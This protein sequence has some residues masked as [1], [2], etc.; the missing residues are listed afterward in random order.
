MFKIIKSELSK[1]F[2][3]K[4][5]YICSAIIFLLPILDYA[6]IKMLLTQELAEQA[7]VSNLTTQSFILREFNAQFAAGGTVFIIITILI[8][9]LITSD[10]NNGTM[11]YSL[12]AVGRG[13]LIVGKIITVFTIELL[14][15]SSILISSILIGILGY[16]WDP[17]GLNIIQ[18]ITVYLLGWLSICSFSMLLMF[19]S[20]K[21]N[22]LIG[23][24]GLSLG[25][26][27]TLS[28]L[29]FV[30]PEKLKFLSLLESFVIFSSYNFDVNF[31]KVIINISVYFIVFGFLLVT[32]FKKKEILL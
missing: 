28:A 7:G 20:N 14:Y 27:F 18:I 26:Y 16:N 1:C 11:K 22:K 13:K 12:M 4:M 21:M 24:I 17:S 2:Y 10:Y 31:I 8:A 30:I 23:T 5:V 15:V 6:I 25:I 29:S 9:T 3:G 19:I 32:S